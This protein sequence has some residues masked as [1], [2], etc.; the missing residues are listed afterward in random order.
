VSIDTEG[1]YDG[2]I[3]VQVRSQRKYDD[4][5]TVVHGRISSSHGVS[6]HDGHIKMHRRREN[7]QAITTAA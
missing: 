4:F 7:A 1:R 6:V 2:S 5:L 3:S